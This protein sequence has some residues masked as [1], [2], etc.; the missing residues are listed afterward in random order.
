MECFI[1]L[2][3]SET[4]ANPLLSNICSCNSAV[5]KQCLE[6]L[7]NLRTRNT[8]PTCSVCKSQY[9]NVRRK[10]DLSIMLKIRPTLYI[11]VE[12]LCCTLLCVF[13]F[14]FSYY[15]ISCVLRKQKPHF[16]TIPMNILL[17]AVLITRIAS[18]V[19]LRFKRKIFCCKVPWQIEIV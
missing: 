16:I 2:D 1:C 15:Q 17:L 9:K 13:I 8:I 14:S 11:V 19:Y 7:L 10:M 12:S 6:R 3:S 18:C 4:N 5:H